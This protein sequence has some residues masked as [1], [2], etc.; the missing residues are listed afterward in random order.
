MAHFGISAGQL[1]RVFRLNRGLTLRE[2]AALLNTSYPVLSRKETGQDELRRPDINSAIDG[3]K[4][5]DWEAHQLWTSA[6]FI[7]DKLIAPAPYRLGDLTP[8]LEA[9][10]H[11]AYISDVL[12]YILAW[13]LGAEWLWAASQAE[14]PIHFLDD[15]FSD[16]QKKRLGERWESYIARGVTIFYERTLPYA[17]D[18]KF[19]ELL[20][21]LEA[22]HGAPF[23]EKWIAVLKD[24]K[25]SEASQPQASDGSGVVVEHASNGSM[26]RYVVSLVVFRNT[27]YYDLV[28]YVPLGEENQ[29][30]YAEVWSTLPKGQRVWVTT[31]TP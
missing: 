4:L 6:G 11:P 13:N 14:E 17:N 10:T 25:A 5:N 19:H 9:M 18:P 8:L 15:L 23:I 21:R 22:R 29:E 16:R 20:K 3:Y 1:L 7:P 27:Q 31:L 24:A 26:I 28:M 30:R 2:A 12:G